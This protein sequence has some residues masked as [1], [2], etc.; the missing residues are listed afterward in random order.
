MRIYLTHCTGI[1]DD[2]LQFTGQSVGPDKLYTSIPIQRFINRCQKQNVKWAIFS[3]LYGIWHPHQKHTWY[4]K[5][6]NTV[7]DEELQ[8]LILNFDE[9][10]KDFSEIWFYNNPSWF[11]SLYKMLAKRSTFSDRITLFSSLKY[12]V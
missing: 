8:K 5:H 4:D 7:T 10:L 12:I 1:K 9:D 2:S 11:H 6:P 3:D